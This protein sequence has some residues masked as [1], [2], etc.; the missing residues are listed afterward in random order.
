MARVNEELYKRKLKTYKGAYPDF[1]Y[2]SLIQTLNDKEKKSSIRS[3]IKKPQWN[4]YKVKRGSNHRSCGDEGK[5]YLGVYSTKNNG[6]TS[7]SNIVICYNKGTSAIVWTPTTFKTIIHRG[8]DRVKN[9]QFHINFNNNCNNMNK[10]EDNGHIRLSYEVQH[11]VV[12]MMLV[13]E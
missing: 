1:I 9:Q 7:K 2:V 5:Q 3:V 4:K 13:G 11:V 6:T 8:H 10:E 12:A